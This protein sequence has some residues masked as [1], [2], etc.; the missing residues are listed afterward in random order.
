MHRGSGSVMFA[1]VQR[2]NAYAYAIKIEN[3]YRDRALYRFLL[4]SHLNKD[5]RKAVGSGRTI[6]VQYHLEPRT[7]ADH[8]SSNA[9]WEDAWID[10]RLEM[11]A[12]TPPLE[13]LRVL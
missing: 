8:H 2:N 3:A 6:A 13:A 12:A 11:F 9:L 5:K 1:I 4:P 7:T 10:L